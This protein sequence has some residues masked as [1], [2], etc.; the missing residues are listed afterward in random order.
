MGNDYS[1]P[2]LF[3]TVTSADL[4]YNTDTVEY[5]VRQ[6]QQRRCVAGEPALSE[7]EQGEFRRQLIRRL[8]I[9]GD[10]VGAINLRPTTTRRQLNG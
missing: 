6:E 8:V 3:T 7:W 1:P 10:A 5:L 2:R 9:Q 4:Q